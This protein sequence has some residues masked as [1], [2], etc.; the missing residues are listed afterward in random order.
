M[1]PNELLSG[2][3]SARISQ[4]IANQQSRTNPLP[5]DQ[6]EAETNILNAIHDMSENM[7]KIR[8]EHRAEVIDAM[9]IK[10]ASEFGWF[11]GGA[12]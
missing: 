10:I 8:P 9:I 2:F 1:N 12:R 3:I 5:P 4:A 6:Q 11:T 7:T